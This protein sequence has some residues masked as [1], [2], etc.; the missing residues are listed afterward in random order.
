MWRTSLVTA[1]YGEA[2]LAAQLARQLHALREP[3]GEAGVAQPRLDLPL[4]LLDLR[5]RRLRPVRDEVDRPPVEVIPHER[6][7]EPGGGQTV[8]QRLRGR[9]E[10]LLLQRRGLP[11]LEQTRARRARPRRPR[12][13]ARDR[14]T[15][16]PRRPGARAAARRRRRRRA[17][18]MTAMSTPSAVS[19]S[20]RLR[21][22]E[23][24]ASRRAT[25]VPSHAKQITGNSRSS[26]RSSF[27]LARASLSLVWSLSPPVGIVLPSCPMCAVPARDGTLVFLPPPARGEPMSPFDVAYVRSQF[28]ALKRTVDGQPA[29][30]LDGPGGTQTPQRVIDAVADYLV[31]H[32]CNIHGAFA[33]SEETDA[34]VQAAHEAGADLLGCHWEEVS[35]GANM[36]TLGLPAQRCRRAGH[37]ARRR[38]ARSPSSTTRPT[39]ARGCGWPSAAPSCA[40][41]PWTSRR[42]PST[43]TRSR[44]S[45]S[46]ARP[47]C[48][49]SATR[50]TPSA[51]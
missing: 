45:W 35:F 38:G 21:T 7:V 47:A 40:R 24:S 15:G 49:P 26:A 36:T 28:P 42:A 19:R 44:S 43:G 29:A 30:Y 27:W 18:L 2:G 23:A 25:A 48:S 31:N 39:A 50:R 8:A 9:D 4:Q 5:A 11:P 20:T 41:S 1:G 46:R 17:L 33:T 10:L 12:S 3:A 32:N 6:D 13:R 22:A 34:V 51:P 16:G 37:P 14:G